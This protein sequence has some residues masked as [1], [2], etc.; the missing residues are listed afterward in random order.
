MN[1]KGFTSIVLIVVLV[2]VM[3]VG[4]YFVLSRKNTSPIENSQT[5]NQKQNPLTLNKNGE[6]EGMQITIPS[7]GT[8][9]NTSSFTLHKN[10]SCWFQIKF[11][12]Q[13]ENEKTAQC[14]N[15]RP[16]LSLTSRA[17]CQINGRL[18]YPAG[19]QLFSIV[20]GNNKITTEGIGV[21]KEN[22]IVDGV[23]AEKIILGGKATNEQ[24]LIQFEKNNLW[25][26][27]THTFSQSDLKEA[28]KL[29]DLIISTF[30]FFR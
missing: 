17:D 30:R 5:Q 23:L 6:Q 7:D 27:Y 19:C 14:P 22:I 10:H 2:A 29:S 3:V 26:R 24:I 18:E 8:I 13:F 1:K 4:G 11:P 21:M 12:S 9:I 16:V 25:Y 28:E 15:E 20:V